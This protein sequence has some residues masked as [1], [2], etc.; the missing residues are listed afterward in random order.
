MR[1]GPARRPRQLR[2]AVVRARARG[3]GAP[4]R[5][6][7]GARAR[8][9]PHARGTRAQVHSHA[10][11][12]AGALGPRGARQ[13][14]SLHAAGARRAAGGDLRWAFLFPF[15]C[16]GGGG[17]GGGAVG[18]VRQARSSA[19]ARRGPAAT[20][21][22]APQALW[23][24]CARRRRPTSR[25]SASAWT[26]ATPCAGGGERQPAVTGDGCPL[27]PCMSAQQGAAASS[28]ACGRGPAKTCNKL[29]PPATTLKDQQGPTY[30]PWSSAKTPAHCVPDGLRGAPRRAGRLVGARGLEAL[31]ALLGLPGLQVPLLA[32]L[33]VVA[34]APGLLRL[35]RARVLLR[36]AG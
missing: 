23:R 7:P 3:A 36:P 12:R 31:G 30:T 29:Q 5:A 34:R 9:S 11:G 15:F 6:P 17:G 26:A 35:Q 14:G 18:V 4:L 20:R 1:V 25:A 33:L 13:R 10:A 21:R 2:Q 22:R 32:L 28:T 19:R 8:A 27:H 16:C 24:S